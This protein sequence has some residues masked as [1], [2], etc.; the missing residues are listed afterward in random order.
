MNILSICNTSA[1]TVGR[2]NLHQTLNTSP[3]DMLRG[4]VCTLK[5]QVFWDVIVGHLSLVPDLSKA[6]SDVLSNTT[7]KTPNQTS[8]FSTGP[9]NVNHCLPGI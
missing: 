4:H 9:E 2:E 5:I 3:A 1:F 6:H 7:M 8:I